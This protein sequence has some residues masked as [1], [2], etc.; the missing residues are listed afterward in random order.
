M[1][2]IVR[3]TIYDKSYCTRIFIARYW[4]IYSS[5]CRLANDAHQ[6]HND[7]R[8]CL[9][10]EN[11]KTFSYEVDNTLLS[12]AMTAGFEWLVDIRGEHSR[13]K[14]DWLQQLVCCLGLSTNEM[15]WLCPP[16][17]SG[18]DTSSPMWRIRPSTALLRWA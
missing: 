5:I 17:R 18:M 7:L 9:R 12:T 6:L 11:M 2:V 8:T 1:L 14:H 16:M 4:F 15:R 3:V 10:R 13:C